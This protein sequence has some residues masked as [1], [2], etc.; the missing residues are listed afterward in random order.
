MPLLDSITHNIPLPEGVS[1]SKD[2]DILVVSKGDSKITREFRHSRISVS[3]SDIE[4]KAVSHT[5]LRAHA[6]KA[7]LTSRR[8]REKKI[9]D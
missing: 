9:A 8:L 4:V 7:Q 1:A 6:T 5:H 3:T 2:G